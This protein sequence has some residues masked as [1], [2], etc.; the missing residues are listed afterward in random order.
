MNT[1]SYLNVGLND[2]LVGAE[3]LDEERLVRVIRRA[4]VV[5][6]GSPTTSRVRRV[7]HLSSAVS[8]QT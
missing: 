8:K 1:R 7:K 6:H 5:D 2:V 3:R 4:D